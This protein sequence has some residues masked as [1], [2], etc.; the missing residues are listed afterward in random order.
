MAVGERH[1]CLRRGHALRSGRYWIYRGEDGQ[2]GTPSGGAARPPGSKMAS[3]FQ[4]I[5]RRGTSIRDAIRL[6]GSR[7]ENNYIAGIAVVV[8][9]EERVEGVLTDGDIRRAL[10]RDVTIDQPVEKIANFDP[11]TVDR[12]LSPRLMRQAI[13]EKARR[14]N[15]D[16]RR[17][18]KIVVV[19]EE[20]RLFDVI[21]LAEILSSDVAD[22]TIAVYG[23][24]FAGLTLAATLAN[25]GI[26][27]I[28]VDKNPELIAGLRSGTPP[29]YEKGLDSLL[30]SLAD[31]N[32]LRLS[33]APGDWVADIHIIAVG[34]PLGH[35]SKPDLTAIREVTTALARVLKRG[36]TVIL[37]STV[38][39]GT[40]RNVV[41]PLLEA[42]GLAVGRDFHLAIAPERTAAGRAL[43]ELKL[44]PQIVGGIDQASLQ[45]AGR[46][47]SEITNTIVEVTSLEAAELVKL[48]NN[49]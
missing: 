8:D 4:S 29:F 45:I 46:V 43:E 24:G 18:D 23:L 41:L 47:F 42:G 49:T 12:R 3:S 22:R 26:A 21:R 5:V 36:D 32:P 10:S 25:A 15:R 28:G 44:L 33:T 16:Y 39:V 9:A 19:D 31:S 20:R 13:V 38:P 11:I 7:P 1:V 14:R 48:M 35:D 27:V 37:R 34:T 17:F 40:T 2:S 6:M 30:L